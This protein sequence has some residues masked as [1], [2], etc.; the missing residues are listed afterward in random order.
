MINP[1]QSTMSTIYW[2]SVFFSLLAFIWIGVEQYCA[3]TP[4]KVWEITA[5]LIVS[6]FPM[7]N[8]C[9]GGWAVCWFLFSD[10]VVLKKKP[11]GL[12]KKELKA[13]LKPVDVGYE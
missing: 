7:V 9:F 5:S 4:I 10:I 13:I 12:T 8:S 2:A 6:F 3:G 1:F 11:P